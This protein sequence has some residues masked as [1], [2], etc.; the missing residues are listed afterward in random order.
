MLPQSHSTTGIR[1]LLEVIVYQRVPI[2]PLIKAR[3]SSPAAI[4]GSV[5]TQPGD[6]LS[7]L[8]FYSNLIAGTARLSKQDIR[9]SLA[10]RVLQSLGKRLT[11]GVCQAGFRMDQCVLDG[12]HLAAQNQF[13][14]LATAF[15]SLAALATRAGYAALR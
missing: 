5:L 12:R 15:A 6:F 1:Y 4:A 3:F 11:F 9:L 10:R 2:S 7:H 13:T 14:S 8:G